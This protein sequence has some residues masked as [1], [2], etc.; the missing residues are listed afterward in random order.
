[1]APRSAPGAGNNNAGS[2]NFKNIVD[3]F[4]VGN[5]EKVP[6]PTNR[7]PA[8]AVAATKLPKE[9][10][11]PTPSES[12]R[13]SASTAVNPKRAPPTSRSRAPSTRSESATDIHSAVNSSPRHAA[14]VPVGR[15][16]RPSAPVTGDVPKSR[17]TSKILPA[18]QTNFDRTPFKNK[19]HLRP[20]SAM[21][22]QS[23]SAASMADVED[24]STDSPGPP[25]SHQL[26]HRRSRSNAENG[27]PRK[28]NDSTDAIQSPGSPRT[29]PRL[30]RS[31][32][33][34]TVRRDSLSARSSARNSM[35]VQHPSE[36]AR[37][38]GE[39]FRTTRPAN[40]RLQN[41]SKPAEKSPPLRSSRQRLPVAAN[42]STHASRQRAQPGTS[43]TVKGSKAPRGRTNFA[44][45]EGK[46]K[47]PQRKIPEIGT[48]DF[49]ARRARI[50][51]SYAKNMKE[52]EERKALEAKKAEEA[53]KA[54]AAQA[55]KEAEEAAANKVKE[56]AEAEAE[57]QP[58]PTPVREETPIHDDDDDV[59]VSDSSDDEHN[60]VEDFIRRGQ[61]ISL[62]PGE[63]MNGTTVVGDDEVSD[64]GSGNSSLL[65]A[66]GSMALKK[67]PS[68]QE[69]KATN[70]Y[71]FFETGSGVGMP[72][73]WDYSP[74]SEP[75][76]HKYSPVSVPKTASPPPPPRQ[77]IQN[78]HLLNIVTLPEGDLHS[79][80]DIPSPVDLPSPQEYTSAPQDFP[81]SHQDIELRYAVEPLS[82]TAAT[83]DSQ[84]ECESL[85][86]T[87]EA[88][89]PKE[90]HSAVDPPSPSY[91]WKPPSTPASPEFFD[92]WKRLSL[93]PNDSV[94][95]VNTP[96]NPR[97]RHTFSEA[98]PLQATVFKQV[99]E[100]LGDASSP[101]WS[102]S[103]ASATPLAT[104]PPG[105]F[106]EAPKWNPRRS[107]LYAP[108]ITQRNSYR[109]S[110]MTAT[111]EMI[112]I[113]M[114]FDKSEVVSLKSKAS[115][116]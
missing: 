108:T 20:S 89:S 84:S 7:I 106:E 52:D 34:V 112:N 73:G 42:T 2:P 81:S 15:G 99:Q 102:S 3:R 115:K 29:S 69:M 12:R 4:N 104:Q 37:G 78:K 109:D 56:E 18:L 63:S 10:R 93:A 61:I 116:C 88:P 94:S 31:G 67:E 107:S 35:E 64:S 103:S 14:P 100:M 17:P 46:R 72:G 28:D 26:R 27:S 24:D 41:T 22:G 101:Q 43:S 110:Q 62:A 85:H 6:V 39:P 98:S 111:G 95:A 59:I 80:V 87:V 83:E 11:T 96:I 60:D 74:D 36:P 49:A 75:E 9:R 48:V 68:H 71:S 38:T 97:Q 91:A 53:R 16:R 58:E 114:V 21:D 30:G 70:R 19:A 23:P 33:P 5:D 44:M 65:E 45:E 79:A 90:L 76:E 57:A 13:A 32:I 66:L 51:A 50:Q 86:S 8:S 105:G 82:S 113:A 40:L 77:P 54:A 47:V 55:A 92:H 25:R 1:M